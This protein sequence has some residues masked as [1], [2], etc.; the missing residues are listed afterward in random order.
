[1][2]NTVLDPS[3]FTNVIEPG[4]AEPMNHTS[5]IR[6]ARLVAALIFVLV[7]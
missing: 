1:M 3:T 6:T 7:L 5:T 2:G 4:N